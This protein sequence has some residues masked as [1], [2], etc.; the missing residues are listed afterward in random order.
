MNRK[1]W[2]GLALVLLGTGLWG[3]SSNVVQFLFQHA[4]VSPTWL[5]EIRLLISGMGLLLFSLLKYGWKKT[6]S[7]WLHWKDR[8]SIVIFG[9]FGMM[10]VQLTF[11]LAIKFGNAAAATLLQYMA[12]IL[13]LIYTSIRYFK[14][15]HLIDGISILLALIGTSLLV[16]GGDFGQIAISPM[17]LFWGLLSAVA[18]SFY[19]L[20]PAALL[21]K[22]T[23]PIVVGW[24]MLIGAIAFSYQQSPWA[25]SFN[26]IEDTS[27]VIALIFVILFGTLLAFTFFLASYRYIFPHE[28]SILSCFE[29]L[30]AVLIGVLFMNLSFSFCDWIGSLL[31]ILAVVLISRKQ[32][33]QK[34]EFAS[35]G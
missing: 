28:A 2:K 16:T 32:E 22:Y 11:F 14:L 23:S 25:F 30:T 19:I 4:D 29:P 20:Q 7:I 12:P 26:L 17:A 35:E 6:C 15:P 1:R 9:I 10:S 3:S 5:V 21:K 24:G 31:I 33:D 8:L 18:L 13:I 34:E 27:V